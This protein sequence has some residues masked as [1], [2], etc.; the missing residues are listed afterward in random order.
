MSHDN[1]T[2]QSLCREYLTRLRYIAKK[3]GLGDWISDIIRANRRN[4][5]E[6][7]QHEVQMLARMVDDER[8][9]REDIPKMLGKSYR[10]CVEDD[11]FKSIMKL[12]K[13]GTYSK[14]SAI[15][16]KRGRKSR[17]K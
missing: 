17:K 8:I 2:L 9:N 13:L 10:Q 7:T 14:I 11:D 16:Y 6:G 1:D 3:H 5:C 15:T 12:R 4:E